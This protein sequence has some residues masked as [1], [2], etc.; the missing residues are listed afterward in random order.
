MR[1]TLVDQGISAPLSKVPRT[2]G[3][4]VSRIIRALAVETGFLKPEFVEELSLVEV[5]SDS[6]AWWAKLPEV[7]RLRISIGLAWEEYYIPTLP[8]VVDHPGEM[9]VD[10]IYMTHDGESLD[11]VLTRR[12]QTGHIITAHEIKATYKS[13]NCIYHPKTGELDLSSQ[14]MWVAQTQSYCKG[15][16]TLRAFLHILFLCGDYTF[17]IIPVLRVLC[18]EYTQEEIDRNWSVIT[19]YRDEAL[20]V[21]SCRSSNR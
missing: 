21:Q 4:H 7:A 11:A 3:V 16:N 13:M 9:C 19:S 2:P 14:W 5:Q 18:I 6:A 8:E 12:G 17:P 15:L 20:G 1:V 10:G